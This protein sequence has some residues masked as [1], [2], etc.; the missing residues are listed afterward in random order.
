MTE[1]DTLEQSIS[2]SGLLFQEH[3]HIGDWKATRAVTP[4]VSAW[5]T[6]SVEEPHRLS[7]E[8]FYEGETDEDGWTYDANTWIVESY[9]LGLGPGCDPDTLTGMYTDRD[10]ALDALR[11]IMNEN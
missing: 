3:P 5:R 6:D 8:L 7:L 11:Q 9:G 1:T 10:E 2:T 4:E